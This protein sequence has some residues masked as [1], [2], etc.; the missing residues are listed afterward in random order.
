[1]SR[2]SH[3]IKMPDAPILPLDSNQYPLNDEKIQNFKPQL[4]IDQ[5]KQKFK[6]RI[7]IPGYKKDDVKVFAG[8]E[9][10]VV[11][12]VDQMKLNCMNIC[13]VYEAEYT[14][15]ADISIGKLRK[16]YQNGVLWL[17]GDFKEINTDDDATADN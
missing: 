17:R 1:M 15:P 8:N 6:L 12:A 2:I 14:L 10:I 7:N 13:K 5:N 3:I 16:W 11:K 9:K 4:I